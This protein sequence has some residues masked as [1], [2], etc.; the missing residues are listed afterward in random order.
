M[1]VEYLKIAHSDLKARCEIP[2][3]ELNRTGDVPLT[4]RVTDTKGVEVVRA[5]ITMYASPRKEKH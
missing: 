2:V 3:E 5:V 4:V 1:N